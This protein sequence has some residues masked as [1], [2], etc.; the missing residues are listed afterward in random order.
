MAEERN[1]HSHHAWTWSNF[2]SLEF[3][4]KRKGTEHKALNCLL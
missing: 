4:W 3:D 2:Q 1:F